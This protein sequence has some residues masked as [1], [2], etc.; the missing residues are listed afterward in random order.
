MHRAIKTKRNETKEDINF[1]GR[2]HL[3]FELKDISR[4]V[5]CEE[6]IESMLLKHSIITHKG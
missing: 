1:D 4:A 2:R 5:G 3:I 6:S